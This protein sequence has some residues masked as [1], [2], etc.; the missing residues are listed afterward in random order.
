MNLFWHR[1]DL[2]IEDNAGLYQALKDSDQVQSIFIFDQNILDE[3]ENPED[4]RVTFI[5]RQ[6]QNL[7]QTYQIYGGDLDVQYGKPKEVITKLIK[8][9]S[10]KRIYTNRDYEGY[11]LDRDAEIAKLCQCQAVTFMTYKDQ[12]IFEK[13]EILKKDGLPYTVFTPYK[14]RWLEKLDTRMSC[15][16]YTSPSPR[17][18]TLSRMPSSA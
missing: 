3:L 7:K 18:A 4:P 9:Y 16:L 14:R 15:L 11:A 5:H 8:K 12:V 17:D 2:R 1:R 6:V 10:P 13:D